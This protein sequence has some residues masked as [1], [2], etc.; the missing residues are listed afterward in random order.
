MTDIYGQR[1]AATTTWASSS[2]HLAIEGEGAAR[3][4]RL[5]ELAPTE[6][7]TLT[8]IA[9]ANGGACSTTTEIVLVDGPPAGGEGAGIPEPV[10]ID[11]PGGSWR[12]RMVP[13]GWHVNIGHSDY[14]VLSSDPRARL[15][16]L[17]AL[18]AKDLTVATTHPANEPLLDQMID[19]LAHA[20]RNL[21]RST[22]QS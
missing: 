21:L 20:E 2:I 10:L 17:V 12:S 15:R 5:A 14:R 4:V 3:T 1:I 16:Y 22:R 9:E 6:T 13:A 19:V 11:D 8:V 7:Y 18:F